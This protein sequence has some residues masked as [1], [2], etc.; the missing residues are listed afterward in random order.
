MLPM[1]GEDRLRGRRAGWFPAWGAWQPGRG[2]WSGQAPGPWVC[3][4]EWPPYRL[5]RAGERV[6]G[7]RAEEVLA[8]P[9]VGFAQWFHPWR[10]A[11]KGCHSHGH[12]GQR[13]LPGLFRVR[14]R[15]LLPGS[16]I[17]PVPTTLPSL[18]VAPGGH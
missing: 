16:S 14:E 18:L 4:V 15:V 13:V 12:V 5:F 1:G 9:V 6:S 2:L 8:A 7:E 10:G 17:S 11:V 3:P